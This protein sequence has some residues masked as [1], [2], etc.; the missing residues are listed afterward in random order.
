MSASVIRLKEPATLFESHAHVLVNTVNC[1]GVMGKGIALEFKKRYPMMY[2]DYRQRCML[3][4]VRVGLPYIYKVDESRWILN[5]PTKDHWKNP[6]RLEWIERGL[7][8]VVNNV[9]SWG[10]RSLAFPALGCTNGGLDWE[11]QVLPL[12]MRILGDLDVPVEIY[13]PK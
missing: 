3:G 5:F 9:K 7:T 13:P 8:Y 6:S 1:C 10:V 2:R 11:H 4:K 12:M